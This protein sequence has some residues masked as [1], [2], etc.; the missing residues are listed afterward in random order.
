MATI[1][2]IV[3]HYQCPKCKQWLYDFAFNYCP[4]CGEPLNSV[5]TIHVTANE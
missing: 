3:T 5:E 4:W 2:A 1:Q